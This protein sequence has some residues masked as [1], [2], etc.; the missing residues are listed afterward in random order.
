MLAI[1]DDAGTH[2]LEFAD[3]KALPGEIA[4]LRERV[5]PICFGHSKMLE[6]LAG[7]VERYFSGRLISFD[8]PVA[9]RGSAFEAGVW[10]ALR[11][12]PLGETRSYGAI[13]RA[14]GRPEAARAVA[15]ANGANQVAIIVPCH[16]VIGADGSL[17]GYGGKIWRK[18]WLLEHER[19]TTAALFKQ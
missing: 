6:A 5:G 9:Q 17:T 16:R 14:I 12:I 15:R 10:D 8:V 11:R 18:Q 3:R 13:A 7:E 19:R 2:L 1:A 4:R